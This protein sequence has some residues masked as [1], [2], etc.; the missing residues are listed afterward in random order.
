MIYSA[1][2]VYSTTELAAIRQI[3]DAGPGSEAYYLRL[4]K[5]EDL[6]AIS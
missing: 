3:I 2:R 5:P 6:I 4:K 1:T